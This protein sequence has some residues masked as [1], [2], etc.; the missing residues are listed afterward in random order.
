MRN[1]AAW[2]CVYEELTALWVFPEQSKWCGAFWII[3]TFF[4]TKIASIT[5]KLNLTWM[6]RPQTICK[7]QHNRSLVIR[8]LWIALFCRAFV[9]YY[10]KGQRFY[11]QECIVGRRKIQSSRILQKIHHSIYCA[12]LPE[13]KYSRIEQSWGDRICWICNCET[14]SHH[15]ACTQH[16]RLWY[17]V[18]WN[19]SFFYTRYGTDSKSI[20][21]VYPKRH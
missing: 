11:G 13:L 1:S 16:K 4:M 17:V 15:T 10:G 12:W 21:R 20:P 7:A 5:L 14:S 2:I 8:D 19:T 18:M 3:A 9:A 6:C